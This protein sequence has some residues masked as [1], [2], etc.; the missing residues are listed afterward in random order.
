MSFL[1]RL[2]H[3]L[4]L[5][6]PQRLT[7]RLELG[8][9]LALR[10][11]ALEEKRTKEEIATELL[12]GALARRQVAEESLQKWET[13]SPREQQVVALIC[14]GYTTNQMAA[15]LSISYETV[16]THVYNALR[17]FG[18]RRRA[19]LPKLLGDWDFSAWEKENRR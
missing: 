5:I 12:S 9:R 14:L 11:L 13:L 17:K 4:G 19:D 6:R 18:L 10:E 16:N 15:H 7:F 1:L 8:D 2:L 3:R